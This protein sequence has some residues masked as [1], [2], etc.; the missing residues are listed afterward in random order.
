MA[1]KRERDEMAVAAAKAKKQRKESPPARR[2]LKRE[3]ASK[4][5]KPGGKR[6]TP[7][8]ASVADPGRNLL[9]S[10]NWSK[11]EGWN[12]RPDSAVDIMFEAL[13]YFKG[14]RD[15]TY[16]YLVE[17]YPGNDLFE[18]GFVGKT[19]VRSGGARRTKKE[20]ED[21]LRYRIARTAWDFALKTGQHQKSENRKGYTKP[22]PTK[23]AVAVVEAV[24]E[25]TPKRRGRPPGSKNKPKAAV[26]PAAPQKRR[27]KRK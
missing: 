19:K 1:G 3:Q 26:V 17:T 13:K 18:Y 4:T 15:K 25:T 22:T 12:P 14:D 10:I 16:D 20:I 6:E 23:R 7:K 24:P 9:G 5:A 11:T 8:K 2:P 27:I 21:Y